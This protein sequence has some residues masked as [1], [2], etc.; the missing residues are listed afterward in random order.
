MLTLFENVTSRLTPI[1]KDTIVPMIVETLKYKNTPQHAV[2]N[3]HLVGWLK[4]CKIDTSEIRVRMMINHIRNT[5]L[6]PCLIASGNGYWVTDDPDVIDKYIDSLNGRINSI[7][8][9]AE[10]L[11]AQ[12][13]KLVK[14]NA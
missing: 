2:T 10:S 6:L 13:M 9:M 11:K 3:K 8:N 14:Q 4:A 7:R 5:N 1:E 12:K